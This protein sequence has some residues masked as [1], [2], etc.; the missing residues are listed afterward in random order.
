MSRRAW[1]FS[2]THYM[3]AGG[4]GLRHG[5]WF[6]PHALL[7]RPSWGSIAAACLSVIQRSANPSRDDC[8]EPI[9]GQSAFCA[10]A[11]PGGDTGPYTHRCNSSA[12]VPSS[13]LTHPYP[14]ASSNYCLLKNE[15]RRIFHVHSRALGSAEEGLS[16]SDDVSDDGSD[17]GSESGE[18]CVS[19]SSSDCNVAAQEAVSCYLQKQKGLAARDAHFISRHCPVFLEKIVQ[20]MGRGADVGQMVVEQWLEKNGVNEL[21]PFFESI[22]MSPDKLDDVLSLVQVS[23]VGE[24]GLLKS[25]EVLESLGISRHGLWDVLE[26]NKQLLTLTAAEMQAIVDFLEGLGVK[27]KDMVGLIEN[28]FFVT[29]NLATLQHLEQIGIQK[30][31]IAEIL[32]TDPHVAA[33]DMPVGNFRERMDFLLACG[34]SESEVEQSLKLFPQLLHLRLENLKRKIQFFDSI[35]LER[36]KMAKI[37]ARWPLVFRQSVEKKL[38]PK[39]EM[40]Q[41][42]GVG[43]AGIAKILTRYPEITAVS[44]EDNLKQ[45]VAFFEANGLTGRRLVKLMTSHPRALTLS[46]N[47]LN[48][49]LDFFKQKGFAPGSVEMVRA[50]GACITISVASL[51]ARFLNLESLGFSLEESREVV[52]QQPAILTVSEKCIQDKVH[53]LVN[54][55]NRFVTEIVRCP[56][57]LL[58]SLELRIKPRHRVLS[59]LKAK[60]LVRE[61]AY[62]LN[63]IMIMSEKR[64]VERFVDQYPV[65]ATAYKG[66]AIDTMKLKKTY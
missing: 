8:S 21:E 4:K 1:T 32:K 7:R 41:S 26:R 42:L 12:R 40:L 29:E 31:V 50:L 15:P 58:Y 48:K 13:P 46:V 43:R 5:G 17:D 28:S 9:S 20:A 33:I 34:L 49:K 44:L 10:S 56:S 52:K 36:E 63:T 30:H 62:S 60:G 54:H 65:V 23:L 51:E 6:L 3:K 61:E 27:R 57:Y 14:W 35:G 64:F 55:M 53:Y 18:I 25:T 16:K 11:H 38:R 24:Q 37:I 39:I 19:S 66:A 22:G 2:T 47:D 59:L 45:K